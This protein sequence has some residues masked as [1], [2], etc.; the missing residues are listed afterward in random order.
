MFIT[1]RP[2]T[3]GPFGPGIDAGLDT[4]VKAFVPLWPESLG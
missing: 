4:T 3:T 1:L 2:F